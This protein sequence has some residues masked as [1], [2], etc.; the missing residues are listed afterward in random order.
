MSDGLSFQTATTNK[1][2]LTVHSK[3][4]DQKYNEHWKDRA[5]ERAGIDLNMP[6]I[7]RDILDQLKT[8]IEKDSHKYVTQSKKNPDR[9]IVTINDGSHV[10]VARQTDK[11]NNKTLFVPV[12]LL[13]PHM[14][15]L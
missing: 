11:V 12:T 9:F 2:L 15:Y 5:K 13:S 10:V 7:K 4:L 8:S 14:Q 6:E 3:A 1:S